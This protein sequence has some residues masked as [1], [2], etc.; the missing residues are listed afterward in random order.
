[1]KLG[2]VG[3]GMIVGWLFRD[4]KVLPEIRVTALCVREKSLEKGEQL[5]RDNSVGAVYTDYAE[6]LAEGDF[7]TVYI[8][9]ANHMHFS[10]AEQALEAGK[11]VIC[12]KP[13]TVHAGEL[14]V[15]SRLAREKK[16]FLW[17]AFK[18]PYSPLFKAVREHLGDVGDIKIA[19]CNFSRISSRYD[20]YSAGNILP[21]FDPECAGG[22]LYDINVYNLHFVTGLFGKPEKVHFFANR[23]FNGVDTS[24]TAILEYGSFHAVCTA[25]KDSTSPSYGVVQGTKGYLRV[26]G[27]VS[28]GPYAEF[29]ANDGTVTRLAEDPSGG[30]LTDEIREFARQYESGDFAACYEMLDHS[31]MMMEVLEEASGRK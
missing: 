20:Q 9:I 22:S 29:V 15:L 31:E 12:E 27:P 16:L 28:S 25:A 11:H 30:A 10:Y 17:E 21:A 26:E 7:D 13:F 23:G 4:I 14:A 5:A 3:N 18:I 2:V 19:Q 8:G 24:G 1:M 6:F